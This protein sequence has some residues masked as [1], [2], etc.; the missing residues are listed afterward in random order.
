MSSPE[1]TTVGWLLNNRQL[2]TFVALVPALPSRPCVVRRHT[3]VHGPRFFF[4]RAPTHSLCQRRP[5]DFGGVLKYILA[6]DLSCGVGRFR[7]N[8]LKRVG[9]QASTCPGTL[10]GYLTCVDT[11]RRDVDLSHILVHATNSQEVIS[12]A[13][14]TPCTYLTLPHKTS[15]DA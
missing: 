12:R 5:V 8:K 1:T 2:P 3:S 11:L 15:L 13:G 9:S 4:G 10:L 6:T 7:N 14:L